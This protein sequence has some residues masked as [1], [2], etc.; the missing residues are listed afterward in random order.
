MNVFL[1]E[2]KEWKTRVASSLEAAKRI[3]E[4]V[5]D[6]YFGRPVEWKS[7]TPEK[8]DFYGMWRA[9]FN[10]GPHEKGYVHIYRETVED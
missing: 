8:D 3:A 2:T 9:T 6:D 4:D 7:A 10:D 1:I 5:A